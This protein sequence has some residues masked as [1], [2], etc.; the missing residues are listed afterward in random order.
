M[1][2]HRS[3][4]LVIALAG[5]AAGCGTSSPP[6]RGGGPAPAS[7]APAA[8][9]QDTASTAAPAPTTA[10]TTR[11]N[12]ARP[13]LRI[14]MGEWAVVPQARAVRPGPVTLVISNRGKQ[15][16]GFE[17]K[18][19]SGAGREHGRLERE[20][21]IVP[22]GKTVRMRV[23]LPTGVYEIECYVADHD[24]LGMQGLMEVRRDAAPLA[25]SH[26][27]PARGATAIR[28]DGF[29]YSPRS[30]TIKVGQSVTWHNADAA[31]H[32]VTEGEG[33]FD[34]KD[35]GTGRRYTRR[36]TQAGRFEYLCALHPAMTGKV[37]VT[38]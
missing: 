31:L 19:E 28:I 38:R 27:A 15:T 23:T 2:L 16:H 13:E 33:R 26:P 10:S 9:Q 4:L 1:R 17:I 11:R 12:S 6:E 32:T 18:A 7:A 34:S 3:S 14:A 25:R 37:T 35:L 5:T 29:A 20:S 36:F 8:S 21:A 30:M 22:P 24:D